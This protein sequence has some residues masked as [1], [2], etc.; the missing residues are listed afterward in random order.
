MAG[1]WLFRID[2]GDHPI[3]AGRLVYLL[4]TKFSNGLRVAYFRDEV[5]P[6]I[7]TQPPLD[8]PVDR[9]CEIHVLTSADDWLNLVWALRTFQ[10]ASGRNY[11]LCIHDDGTLK[12]ETIDSL[13]AAFPFARIISRSEADQRAAEL[14]APFPRCRK[15]RATNKLSLKVL[16]FPAFLD[17]ERMILLDSD[18]LFFSKP[19]ALLAALD[20]PC[21][22]QNTLNRDWREGYTIDL[23]ATRPLLDFDC[24]AFINS[25]LGLIHKASLRLEWIENFLALPGIDS[26]SHQIEQTLIALCSAKFGFRMLP[27]VYDVHP[28]PRKTD[29]PSRHY[30]GPMR[31]L[32]YEEGIRELAEKGFLNR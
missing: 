25:G 31:P 1:H 9:S 3:T 32:M 10:K 29:A 30:A 15:L 2:W 22:T 12:A 27:A 11:A 19:T 20:D 26:H 6:R 21:F 24:P 5:R 16:D 4:K 18:V 17:A 13:R 7:L 14:L 28:G 23:A 8:L